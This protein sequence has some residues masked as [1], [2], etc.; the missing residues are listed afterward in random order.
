MQHLDT[1]HDSGEF[2]VKAR[3]MEMGIRLLDGL[4][5]R[6]HIVN[7]KIIPVIE[8]PRK[9]YPNGKGI[10]SSHRFFYPCLMG[11]SAVS[12]V[13]NQGTTPRT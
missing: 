10:L 8:D 6:I 13:E 2:Q 7:I 5:G 4:V 9:I 12:E 1:V 3:C 11:T